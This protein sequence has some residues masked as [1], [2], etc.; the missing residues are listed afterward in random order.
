M[1]AG[2]DNEGAKLGRQPPLNGVDPL[3]RRLRR[4]PLLAGAGEVRVA[5]SFGARMLGLA[6]LRH[7]AAPVALLLPLTRSV[8]TAGMRFAIDLEWIDEHGEVIRVDRA[9]PP[10]RVRSCRRARG[11]IERPSGSDR[12]RCA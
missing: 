1:W 3:P 4:L 5:A 6:L 10:F 12:T 9:V 11:V 8:H 7:P 2:Q